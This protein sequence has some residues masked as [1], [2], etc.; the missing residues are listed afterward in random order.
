[1]SSP[2]E[3]KDNKCLLNFDYFLNLSEASEFVILLSATKENFEQ[4][5]IFAALLKKLISLIKPMTMVNLF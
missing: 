5:H 1:M 2:Q 4:L 3:L